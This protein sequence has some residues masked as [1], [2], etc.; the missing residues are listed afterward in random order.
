MSTSHSLSQQVMVRRACEILDAKL[1]NQSLVKEGGLDGVRLPRGI[2]CTRGQTY[3]A[4][5]YQRSNWKYA[6]K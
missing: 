5:Q 1:F 2:C 4:F 3:D 6:V